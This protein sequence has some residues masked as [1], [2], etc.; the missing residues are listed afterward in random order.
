[1]EQYLQKIGGYGNHVEE[2]IRYAYALSD[3]YGEAAAAA[4]CEMYDAIATASNVNIPIAEPA[5]T[6]DYKEVARAVNG[7]VKNSSE[8]QIPKTV[9]RLVK[10]T[11]AD[12]T[13]KNALR[14]GAQFAWIPAGDTC[15]FCLAIASRGWQYMSKN[16]LKNGHAEHIHANCDCAYAIRFD[17]NTQYAS[18]DPE[19]YREIYDNAEGKTSK[20]KINSIRKMMYQENKD[21][22]N[23]QKRINEAKKHIDWAYNG[24]TLKYYKSSAPGQGQLIVDE[25]VNTSK[26]QL[27]IKMAK[28]LHR[29]FGGDIKVLGEVNPEG[30]KNPDYLWNNKY[31]D[32]KT[33]TTAKAANHAIKTGLT[34]INTNPGGL[35]L[36][37]GNIDID[38][39]ELKNV[40][41]KR[42]QWNKEKDV[43]I[44][45]KNKGIFRVIE[46]RH[47]E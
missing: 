4:A 47:K 23:A 45:I 32:L 2:T 41:D 43:D 1:M 22:I 29:V 21:R 19:K 39:E 10:R 7:T 46:Y 25:S 30:V 34:Q 5:P 3:R 8:S 28:D 36:D 44:I 24:A 37:Y 31:W 17:S 9:G 33:T 42:M 27:E 6:P 12:T 35:I 40:I 14:D 15:A 16:A 38:F 13:L 26:S 20:E 11:G 18:Y